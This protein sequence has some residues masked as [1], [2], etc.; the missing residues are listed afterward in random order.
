M[1]HSLMLCIGNILGDAVSVWGALASD[2]AGFSV[3]IDGGYPTSYSGNQYSNSS[4]SSVVLASASN[5]GDGTHIITITNA[6]AD[7]S[8]QL[9]IDY[10]TLYTSTVSAR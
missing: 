9:E 4:S 7:G 5:L 1:N 2:K 8:S 10:V 3:S 6:P